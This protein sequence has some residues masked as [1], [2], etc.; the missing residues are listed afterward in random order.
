MKTHFSTKRILTYF[1]ASLVSVLSLL[2]VSFGVSRIRGNIK[3][4]DIRTSNKQVKEAEKSV[5]ILVVENFNYYWDTDYKNDKFLV[6]SGYLVNNSEHHF[7]QIFRSIQG[8]IKFE[9]GHIKKFDD[10]IKTI[11]PDDVD[12]SNMLG[13]GFNS[14]SKSFLEGDQILNAGKKKYFKFGHESIGKLLI[15]TKGE[16]LY[17]IE[18]IRFKLTAEARTPLNE[19]WRVDLVECEV[20]IKIGQ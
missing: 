17:P 1:L 9:T 15:V 10:Q 20:P 4:D 7:S 13:Y 14:V 2:V 11:N 8:E 19:V 5:P 3:S 18:Y 6:V 12:F 16:L